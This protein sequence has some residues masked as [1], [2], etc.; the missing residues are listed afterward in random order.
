LYR[1]YL[2]VAPTC[3]VCGLDLAAHDSG[4]G[5]AVF[6]IFLLGFTVVPL[7]IVT[8]LRVDWPLW[9]HAILWTVVILGGALLLLRPI[10]SLTTALQYRYRR[11]EF[12]EGE[13]EGAED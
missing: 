10:K 3:D 9:V 11:S 5:P 7:A 1:G 6:L 12:G 4:D 13:G 2:I 8:G